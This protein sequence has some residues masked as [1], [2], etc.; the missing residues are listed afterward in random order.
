VADSEQLKCLAT[1]QSLS[2]PPKIAD[3]LRKPLPS[4]YMVKFAW[5]LSDG[6]GRYV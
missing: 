1:K 4:V 6:R 2:T 3:D 5:G